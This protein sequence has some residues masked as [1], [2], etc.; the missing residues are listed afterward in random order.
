MAYL[1]DTCFLSEG[2]NPKIDEGVASW[3]GET[4]AEDRYTSVVS[5]AELQFGIRRLAEGARK[6]QL[7]HWYDTQLRP[8][9]GSRILVFD[10]PTALAWAALRVAHPNCPI[11]DAQLA[12]TALVHNLTLVTRNTRDFAFAG[13]SVFNPWRN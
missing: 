10:E 7:V 5:L 8:Q 13:L 1:L 12:A 4:A 6:S 11:V 3:L 9:I 2:V